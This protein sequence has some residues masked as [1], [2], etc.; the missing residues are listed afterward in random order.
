MSKT[1]TMDVR[2][3]ANIDSIN[4][5]VSMCEITHVHRNEIIDVHKTHGAPKIKTYHRNASYENI[6][7]GA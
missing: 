3:S 5:D 1:G 4:N 6:V 2:G 7:R